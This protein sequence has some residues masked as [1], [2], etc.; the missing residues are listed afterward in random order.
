MLPS[1]KKVALLVL[2]SC[3]FS[4][5]VF[6]KSAPP[7][8]GAEG[9]IL[10][11]AATGQVL[12]EKN[13][14]K[15]LAPAST[16]KMITAILAIESG[17]LDEKITVS[18][19]AANTPG[20]TMHLEEGQIITIRELL[21]GL[22]MR[23]GNDGAI[24]IA[25]SIGGSV[26]GF[27]EMMNKKASEI[28]A[29][30]TYFRNPHGLSAPGHH[31]TAFDLA[32]I[33]RYAMNNPIFAEIVGTRN[34]SIDWQDSNGDEHERDLKNTNKLLWMLEEADGVKTGTTNEAGPCLVSSATKNGQRLIAVTLHDPAR[35][36]DSQALLEWGFKEFSLFQY[37]NAGDQVG[38]VKVEKGVID[39]LRPILTEDAA[40]VVEKDN[41]DKIDTTIDLPDKIKS[42]IYKGQQIGELKFIKDGKIIKSFALLSPRDVEERTL[43]NLFFQELTNLFRLFAGW[44]I[45]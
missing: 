37:G 2:F 30:N 26:D 7:S 3:C 14:Y 35:W 17:R 42:P 1:I 29:Y 8:L 20:S 31:S 21:T 22:L 10:M 12:Y 34:T 4:C 19:N 25:E 15:Q 13:A 24:A 27:V 44:G 18:K 38:D 45:L 23:S 43:V 40:M 36:K 16:T 39:H 33:A 5:I 9:A 6:A 32:W 28:G 11:D 41:H